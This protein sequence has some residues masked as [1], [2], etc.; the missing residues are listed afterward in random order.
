MFVLLAFRRIQ[1][2]WEH[3]EPLTR[4]R[5]LQI[6]VH[7]RAEWLEDDQF[8]HAIPPAFS[9]LTALTR[10]SLAGQGRIQRGWQHLQPLSQ[11]QCLDLQKAQLARMLRGLTALWELPVR[12]EVEAHGAAN[13]WV[14]RF[15]ARTASL[16]EQHRQLHECAYAWLRFLWL[17]LVRLLRR[18]LRRLFGRAAT[19]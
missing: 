4:L 18:L 16:I 11:L 14:Q 10:L 17:V 2:G 6:E 1:S 12:I 13:S 7:R 5:E 8:L 19:E 3:L 9:C 15:N